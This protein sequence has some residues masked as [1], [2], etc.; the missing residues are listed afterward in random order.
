M[1]DYIYADLDQIVFEGREQSYGAYQMRR[2]YTRYLSRS[3]I[4]AFLLFMSVTAL[5]KMISWIAPADSEETD[6][7]IPD[8]IILES[9]SS[10]EAPE[11]EKEP[12]VQPDLPSPPARPMPTVAFPIPKPTPDDEVVQDEPFPEDDDLDEK[13]VGLTTQDGDDE[14]L[15]YNWD[16]FGDG[17]GTPDEV[18]G[19]LDDAEDDPYKYVHLENPPRPVNMDELKDLIGYP[20]LAVEAGIE[21]EVVLRIYIDKRGDY[22]KHIVAKNPHPILTRAVEKQIHHLKMTPGIQG[23]RPIKVWVTLP[24]SFSL[25]NG[26]R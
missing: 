19:F 12:E 24:V 13:K 22:L 5:P 21:G 17:T 4:I 1:K 16:D 20:P 7:I 6:T 14:G 2:Q 25:P 9:L 11:K 8:V 3:A 15:D 26:G 18:E 23:T 10:I